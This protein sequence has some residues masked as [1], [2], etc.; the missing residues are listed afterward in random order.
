[1]HGPLNRDVHR[2]F[3]LIDPAITAQSFG[4]GFAKRLQI[5]QSFLGARILEM[6]PSCRRPDEREHDGAKKKK[7]QRRAEPRRERSAR[8]SDVP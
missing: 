8:M 6:I 3:G 4:I 7:E 1:L 5:L 2:P